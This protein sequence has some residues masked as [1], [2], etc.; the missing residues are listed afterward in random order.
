V[1][2]GCIIRSAI[3]QEGKKGPTQRFPK[4]PEQKQTPRKLQIS[5]ERGPAKGRKSPGK[6]N[7]LARG[8]KKKRGGRGEVQR[9]KNPSQRGLRSRNT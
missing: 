3:I 9:N 6:K 7:V 4:D 5:K 2:P 8:K 1:K